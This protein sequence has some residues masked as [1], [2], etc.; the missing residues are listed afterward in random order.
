MT[1]R[2]VSGNSKKPGVANTASPNGMVEPMSSSTWRGA[3]S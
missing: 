3:S 1:A 2:S